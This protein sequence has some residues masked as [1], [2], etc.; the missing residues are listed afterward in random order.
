MERVLM[1]GR[2]LH[3]STHNRRLR[4]KPVILIS[5]LGLPARGGLRDLLF[6]RGLE[7]FLDRKGQKSIT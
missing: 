6:G 1:P 7:F 2:L 3:L 5:A 4:G